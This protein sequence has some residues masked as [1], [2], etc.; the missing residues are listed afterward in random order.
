VFLGIEWWI[1]KESSGERLSKSNL[2]IAETVPLPPDRLLIGIPDNCVKYS[3]GIGNEGGDNEVNG[4]N[5]A[6]LKERSKRT[7]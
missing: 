5:M 3:E 7:L 6:A 4:S 2:N 1:G